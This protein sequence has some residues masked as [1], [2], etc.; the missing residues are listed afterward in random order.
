MRGAEE[1]PPEQRASPL[2]LILQPHLELALVVGDLSVL[3][4]RRR[5][6]AARAPCGIGA[7]EP[8]EYVERGEIDG[9]F[10]TPGHL[11][12][13]G[14]ANVEALVGNILL[15]EESAAEI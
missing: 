9:R 14:D 4:E 3:R 6:A 15:R 2:E 10:V 1:S 7:I 13:L 5:L 11:E 12:G 8:V